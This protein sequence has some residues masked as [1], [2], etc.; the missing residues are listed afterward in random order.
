VKQLLPEE[1]FMEAQDVVKEEQEKD[2]A[3]EEQEDEADACSWVQC[4][5]CDKWRK[6]A[7]GV[8]TWQGA[9]T[10]E[11][12]DWNLASASCG[13][14]EDKES[15]KSNRSRILGAFRSAAAGQTYRELIAAAL[16]HHR[17]QASVA[18]ISNFVQQYRSVKSLATR[19][20][21][22]DGR[23]WTRLADGC[24]KLV[25]K[26]NQGERSDS[27]ASGFYDNR[28]QLGKRSKRSPEGRSMVCV[29]KKRNTQVR[30]TILYTQVQY[31]P[32]S[33]CY[34]AVLMLYSC[35]IHAVPMLYSYC[36]YAVLMLYSCCNHAVIML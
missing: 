6:L 14:G 31:V 19:L 29:N 4:E 18:Q 23:C 25:V 30:H 5:A 24:Y 21:E 12:N 3:K 8:D 26:P 13:V 27:P 33:Y 22:Y 10:C 35:C 16:H 34:R 28:S 11:M 7:S 20:S 9:F 2:V 15:N 36:T 32:F 1:W 17:G